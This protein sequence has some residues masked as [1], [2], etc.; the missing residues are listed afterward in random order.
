MFKTLNLSPVLRC[1]GLAK[2][3]QFLPL[4]INDVLPLLQANRVFR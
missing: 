3:A 2:R 1:F 4:L